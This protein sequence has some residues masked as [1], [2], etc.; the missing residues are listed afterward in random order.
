M[1]TISGNPFIRY[2]EKGNIFLD[3]AP[4][5]KFTSLNETPVMIFFENRIRENARNFKEIFSSTFS[6]FE[7]FYS[8]KANFLDSV[9]KILSSE[10]IGMELVGGPELDLALK[11]KVPPSQIIMG[12]PYL[13]EAL[14]KKGINHK[15]KEIIVYDLDY[16]NAVN[17]IAK[18]CNQVQ[19]VCLRVNSQKYESKLGINITERNLKRIKKQVKGFKNLKI[20]TILSHYTSQMNSFHQYEKNI[21]AIIE[22]AKALKECVPTLENL[23]LGGGFPEATV[24]PPH[25]LKRIASKM[26]QSLKASK[27]DFQKIYFEPGRYL[28]GD[29]G[30]FLAEVLNC[31]EH[32]WI[33]LNVGNHLCPRF[34]RCSLRFYNASRIN[35]AHKYPANFAG[36]VPTEQDV[37]SKNYFFTKRVEN[38]DKILITNVAAYCLTF[39]N[40]FPY[41]LPP[42]YLIK[43]ERIKKIFNPH[44][45]VD[46]SLH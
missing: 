37:L 24:M 17:K 33:F 41:K 42:I 8:L 40:R 39:S 31:S 13:P 34:A 43:N 38:G 30:L 35:D 19:D 9:C 12:G 1:K 15:V 16:L 4:I 27:F 18:K 22:A 21:N 28:V 32:R 46:F 2:D 3:E 25:Q 10:G 23:N 26:Y 20:K 44:K 29:S 36:I 5:E 14:I 7:G 11:C 45:D 6:N